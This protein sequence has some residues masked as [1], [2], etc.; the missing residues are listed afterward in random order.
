MTF[1][2]DP[3]KQ[4]QEVSFSRKANT[5]SPYYVNK[6]PV[7]RSNSQKRLGVFLDTKLDFKEHLTNTFTNANKNVGLLK[8]ILKQFYP[9]FRCLQSI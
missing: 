9:G 7:M 2:P 4:A 8:E 1:I 6:N 5:N 3:T